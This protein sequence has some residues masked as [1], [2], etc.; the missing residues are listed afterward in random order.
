MTFK[1]AHPLL[2]KGFQLKHPLFGTL[3]R[4]TAKESFFIHV[5]PTHY[6]KVVCSDLD[7]YMLRKV[8][9]E[10]YELFANIDVYSLTEDWEVA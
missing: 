2:L 1:D 3:F 7:L 4:V 9:S 5:D 8:N 6:R 10:I